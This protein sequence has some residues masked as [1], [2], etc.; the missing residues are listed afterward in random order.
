MAVV[1]AV[2]VVFVV[3]NSSKY[4]KDIVSTERNLPVAQETVGLTS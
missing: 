2:P 1:G 4:L 3:V